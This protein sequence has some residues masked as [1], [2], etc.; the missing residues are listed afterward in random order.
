MKPGIKQTKLKGGYRLR[1]GFVCRK[2]DPNELY[3]D[4]V[5]W[6]REDCYKLNDKDVDRLLTFLKQW[7]TRNHPKQ[8]SLARIR[9]NSHATIRETAY[10]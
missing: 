10:L 2:E 9:A 1:R 7:Q 3:F 5:M 8:E 4:Q 6:T